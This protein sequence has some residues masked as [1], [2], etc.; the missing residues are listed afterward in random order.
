MSMTD[1]DFHEIEA[2]VDRLFESELTPQQRE[3]ATTLF[4]VA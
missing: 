2:A 4:R 1:K 3:D